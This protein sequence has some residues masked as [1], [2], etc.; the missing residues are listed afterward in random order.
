MHTVELSK[1]AEHCEYGRV[2]NNKLRDTLVCRTS[3]KRI[4]CR[5]LLEP[6][7]TFEKAIEMT[8]AEEAAEKDAQH[9]MGVTRDK[10]LSSIVYSGQSPAI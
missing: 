10:D 1:V 8:S 4:Q 6:G 7:L 2:L 3:N 9:L 5:L